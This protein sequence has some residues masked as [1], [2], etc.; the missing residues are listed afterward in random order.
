MATFR[1]LQPA[2]M[3]DETPPAPQSRPLLT[4]KPKRTVTL[5]ACVACRKR[6]SKCDGNRP[7][8]TCCTQKDTECLYELGPNEKPSQAMK[9]KNEEMQGELS[10]LRQLYDFL[11][12]R[13]EQEA[14]EILRRIRETSP[15]SSPSQHIQQL[16]DFVRHGELPAPKSSQSPPS[17]YHREHSQPLTLPSIRFALDA[18]SNMDMQNLPYPG[19]LSFG[20]EGPA[21][22]RRKYGSDADLS[23]RSGTQTTLL[24]PTSIEAILHSP[25]NGTIKR[26][27]LDSRLASARDWTAVTNDADLL[28]SILA[29]WTTDEYSFYHYLDR[30]AFLDDMASG[31]SDF[32]S[33]LLVNALL[34]SACSTN[35]R[36]KDR[37]IPFS[38]ASIMTKF[39][40]EATRLWDLEAGS[41]SLTRI[42]AAICL[43]LFL[44]KHGRDKSGHEF[45]VEACKI[46]KDL[47][48]FDAQPSHQVHKPQFAS[49]NQW[50][51]VRAVTAWALFSFQLNMSF[52]YSFPPLINTL[53]F[54]RIPYQD[55]PDAEAMFR[56]ECT[57]NIILLDCVNAIHSRPKET[58]Q[59]PPP[60]PDHTEACHVRLKSWWQTRPRSIRPELSPLK[61]HLLFAM[62]YHTTVIK[63]FQPILNSVGNSAT[64]LS[65]EHAQSV[66]FASLREIRGLLTVQERR[67]GWTSSIGLV[68]HALSVASF[69]SLDEISQT[70]PDPTDA[71]QSEPYRGLLV[72]LRALASLSSY[73][74]YAQPLFRLLTQKCQ[75]LNLPL[76]VELQ[77]TVD[78]YTTEEWTRYVA[79]VVSS[80][81]IADISKT[82]IDDEDNARMDAIISAWEDLSIDEYAK[83]KERRT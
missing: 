74:F 76:P 80:Q 56:S 52:T 6:K 60:D 79:N 63:L 62:M 4:Q 48:L 25:T 14:M 27:Q 33:E 2:P 44:G 46:S 8:C 23:V 3:D 67:Y 75:T 16:A 21:P 77:T 43:Y 15:E 69:G 29:T 65:R 64:D 49:Q 39:F 70:Y 36:V 18:P 31:R 26:S 45:L 32:C 38:E 35:P 42:H 37:A 28:E 17:P 22:Q 7:V 40:K 20:M 19:I 58:D 83:G 30:N 59:S 57:K 53:P 13:P 82:T 81:Y 78:H 24:P 41:C 50:D 47:G 68:L 72:C 61:E 55:D 71:T 54:V 12:L 9:R 1:A 11:R 51:H 5:G 73:N 34:A 10:N 66:T